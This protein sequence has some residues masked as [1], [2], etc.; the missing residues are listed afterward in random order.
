MP[1]LGTFLIDLNFGKV[2]RLSNLVFWAN[3]IIWVVE[4][5]LVLTLLKA[6]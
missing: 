5:I 1:N 4:L 2:L 6:T 3:L